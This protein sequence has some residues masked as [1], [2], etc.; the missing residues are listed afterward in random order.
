MNF[1]EEASAPKRLRSP[2]E[3]AERVHLSQSCLA[4][5]RMG[6]C[7]PKY[8]KLGR[9]VFYAD[10]DIEEFLRAQ[11]RQSTSESRRKLTNAS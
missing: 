5:W 3:T 9:R 2:K 11:T 10:E 1:I 6:A 8:V 4:K 7:G